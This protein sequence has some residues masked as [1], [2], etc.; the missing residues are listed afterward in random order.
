MKK[1]ILILSFIF[2][3]VFLSGCDPD[4]ALLASKQDPYT[5]R[6]VYTVK[7]SVT[8]SVEA[9]KGIGGLIPLPFVGLISS[10]VGSLVLAYARHRAA[11]KNGQMRDSIIDGISYV[12]DDVNVQLTAAQKEEI[13]G[14]LRSAAVKAG[15]ATEIDRIV[16]TRP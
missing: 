16:H 4:A 3:G 9:A 11:V 6:E 14:L 2:A 13:K 7:P 5:G 8:T 10:T 12:F 1:T 15:V